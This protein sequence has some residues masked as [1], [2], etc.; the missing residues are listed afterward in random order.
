MPPQV[1]IREP[2]RLP[3]PTHLS[4]ELA[5]HSSFND[6]GGSSRAPCGAKACAGLAFCFALPV[7]LLGNGLLRSTQR[8][9]QSECLRP[10]S[11][12]STARPFSAPFRRC[13]LYPERQAALFLLLFCLSYGNRRRQ[14]CERLPTF[15]RFRMG[16]GSWRG[17]HHP[18][19]LQRR[20][21]PD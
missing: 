18:P 16:V 20:P 8:L 2:I 4:N 7:A 5:V 17:A 10:F 15:G 3:L 12:C 11:V 13:R 14:S 6:P 21:G 9:V 1:R 19:R